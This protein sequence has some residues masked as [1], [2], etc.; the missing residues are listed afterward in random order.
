VSAEI[1]DLMAEVRRNPAGKGKV[2]RAIGYARQNFW[3]LREFADLHD[4][5]RQARQWLTCAKRPR[6]SVRY[7]RLLPFVWPVMGGS[8]SSLAFVRP[9]A[10]AAQ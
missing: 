3:P 1:N 10:R 6:A 4:V 2:E 7:R 8:I 9:P 5:N